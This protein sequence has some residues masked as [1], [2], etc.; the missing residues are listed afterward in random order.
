[1]AEQKTSP[2]L[3]FVSSLLPENHFE[4][5]R[6]LARAISLYVSCCFYCIELS[7]RRQ[8]TH[9]TLEAAL[10]TRFERKYMV[11]IWGKTGMVQLRGRGPLRARAVGDEVDL[12][13]ES[14][15]YH[16]DRRETDGDQSTEGRL[17]RTKQ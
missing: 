14:I 4:T 16:R 7:R 13:V 8:C 9:T 2:R 11:L 17:G 6:G 12:R 15:G 3:V 1:M 5:V 10:L